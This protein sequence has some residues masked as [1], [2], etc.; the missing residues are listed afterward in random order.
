[1]RKIISTLLSALLL[2]SFVST[3]VFAAGGFN[4]S[5][6]DVTLHP[7]ESTSFSVSATNAAGRINISSSDSGV[8][9]ISTGAIFLDLDSENVTITAGS[10]GSATISIVASSNFATYDEEIL[11]G[12]TKTIAVN[13]VE[14]PQPEP[15]PQ[16]KPQPD[17]APTPKPTPTPASD[18]TAPSDSDNDQ[19]SS[20]DQTDTADTSDETIEPT[21]KSTNVTISIEG[22]KIT[23]KNGIYRA[24]VP[25]DVSKIVVKTTP[26]DKKTT[27]TGGG[28]IELKDGVN[29]VKIVAT[30]ED[31]TT[32][33]YKLEITREA[34]H[35]NRNAE[36]DGEECHSQQPPIFIIIA[37]IVSILL[38]ALVLY[39]L[40]RK[41]RKDKDEDGGQDDW[42]N[43]GQDE[44]DDSTPIP[45]NP[46]GFG[47]GE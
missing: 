46:F 41:I 43:Y 29:N 38:F 21:N 34:A 5:T 35:E 39:L 36:C 25:H 1:M 47:S 32:R 14:V 30:A 22:Y 44:G 12:Q 10:L 20:D 40:I 16:P 2:A 11:G 15:E 7:G 18:S 4:V 37:L 17:P 23:K 24:T 42:Q 9:S 33:T 45:D 28:E 6:S 27:V 8:A 26:E 3:K 13:V 31:G 19:S